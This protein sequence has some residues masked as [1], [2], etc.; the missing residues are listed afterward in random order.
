MKYKF[1]SLGCKVNSYENAALASL[2]KNEG[3]IEDENNPDV[4]IINTCSVTATADQKSRQHIRKL[5]KTY[6]NSVLVVMGC[7]S[8]GRHDFIR[9][10]IKPDIII[11]T[12]NRNKIP[13]LINQFL[14]DKKP[15]DLT[16]E[17]P[18]LFD[19][20]EFGVTSFSDNIR[21][22]L[23][24]QDGCDNFC[25][26]C[27]IPFVRGKSRSRKP[28]NIIREAEELV[29]SGYQEIVL[30]GIHVGGYGKD[31]EG[32]SFSKLVEDLSNIP[33]LKSLRISS[34]EESEI[35]DHLIALV[36]DRKNIAKHL[37]IPLQ[38]G[39][40]NI[41]KAMHRKYDEDQFK[42]TLKKIREE[43]PDIALT[44]DV[45][46]GFP[47]ETEEDFQETITTIKECDFNMLHV[48]PFSARE[49][50]IAYKLPN[51]I[52]PKI[53]DE[54]VHVLLNLSNELWDKYTNE[55]VQKEVEVLIEQFDHKSHKYV[56]HTTNYIEVSI[57]S[58]ENIIGKY[59][60]TTY[61]K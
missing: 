2:L 11:G 52:D 12:S 13:E 53:K 56:G 48:F 43:I 9:D 6:P 18:R 55:F 28:E 23:K 22:Y 33:N 45:I 39:S 14:K 49:K 27:L 32:Y 50:T 20:E 29:N 19:Y 51:Q 25:S 40:T 41:L 3:Y 36:R 58:D 46:V 1:I 10:E 44:T 30:T 24:I 35:D 7:Y 34:I 61:K 37:H 47:G 31:L 15:I 38:S 4:T 26:Y 54:R 59:V 17:N 21:S 8:Q 42:A 5:R 57:E 60:K 16:E